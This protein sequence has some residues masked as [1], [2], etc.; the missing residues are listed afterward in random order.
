MKVYQREPCQHDLFRLRGDNCDLRVLAVCRHPIDIDLPK[1]LAGGVRGDQIMDSLAL[2]ILGAGAQTVGESM[3]GGLVSTEARTALVAVNFVG[4]SSTRDCFA[5]L[6]RTLVQALSLFAPRIFLCLTGA[7]VTTAPNEV[8]IAVRS[9]FV[10]TPDLLAEVILFLDWLEENGVLV[11]STRGGLGI[12]LAFLAVPYPSAS[13]AVRGI[14]AEGNAILRALNAGV[15][16]TIG[17]TVITDVFHAVARGNI[18]F[19]PIL[20]R[21]DTVVMVTRG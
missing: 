14:P 15:D 5:V 7:E 3:S 8:V 6:V 9:K 12:Q 2:G 13:L 4:D 11:G 20:L 10:A 1:H 18:L 21:A 16:R 19:L 17:A